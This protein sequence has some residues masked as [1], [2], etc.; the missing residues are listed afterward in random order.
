[1]ADTFY[2]TILYPPADAAN[3]STIYR[4]G[5]FMTYFISNNRK[6]YMDDSL[7]Q[8]FEDYFYDPVDREKSISKMKKMGI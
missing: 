5:T 7:V 8:G 6:R 1:M 2:S 4:I 3:T